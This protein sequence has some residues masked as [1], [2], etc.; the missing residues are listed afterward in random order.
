MDF[1]EN[2]FVLYWC[3]TEQNWPLSAYL[4]SR[5]PFTQKCSNFKDAWTKLQNT[6]ESP[7]HFWDEKRS[8]NQ[9]IQQVFATGNIYDFLPVLSS[10]SWLNI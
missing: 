2:I 4:Y 3:N 9:M 10:T 6:G 1:N 7:A 5:H 8:T